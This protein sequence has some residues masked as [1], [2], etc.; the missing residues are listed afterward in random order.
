MEGP[1]EHSLR[2]RSLIMIL[3]CTNLTEN[4]SGA[5]TMLSEVIMQPT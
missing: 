2:G 4:I 3:T 5:A 1:N